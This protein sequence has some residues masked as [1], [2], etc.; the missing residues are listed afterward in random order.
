MALQTG[1]HQGGCLC[2]SL[3]FETRDQ[4]L[5][6][7]LCYC[8]FCQRATGSSH[9]VE[10]IFHRSAFEVVAGAPKIYSARSTGSGKQVSVHFCPDCGTKICLTFERFPD[11][12]GV[13]AGT[14]DNPSW[15]ERKRDISAC[16][17]VGSAQEG[18]LIPAGIPVFRA[19]RTADD[20]SPNT[21]EIFDAPFEIKRA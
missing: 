10:P 11:V 5:R 4:P 3:R 19:H 7:T 17:F 2:A 12:V 15:F 6:L 20:G 1:V 16:L 21:P 18:A 8:S 9:M 14:F 13:Y